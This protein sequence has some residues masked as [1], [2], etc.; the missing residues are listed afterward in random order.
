MPA[1][2]SNTNI[3]AALSSM[4]MLLSAGIPLPKV[5][6]NIA[7]VAGYPWR[8]AFNR[9]SERAAA[10][11]GFDACLMELKDAIPFA[12]RIM[13][14]IGWGSGRIDDI[15]PKIIYRRENLAETVRK[16]RSAMIQP[17]L[18]FL[19]A[20]FIIPFP[21]LILGSITPE[22][23]VMIA[24]SPI[25]LVGLVWLLIWI[26]LR[27]RMLQMSNQKITDPPASANFMDYLLLFI[28]FFRA[29]QV[30]RN[31]AE[32]CDLLG[33]LLYAGVRIDDA[34]RMTA[35]GLPNGVYR[36]KVLKMADT[37]RAGG[38]LR[39]ALDRSSLWPQGFVD[40]VEVADISGDL[41]QVLLKRAEGYREEYDRAVRTLGTVLARGFYVLVS[42][43]IAFHI[44]KGFTAYVGMINANLPP[45]STP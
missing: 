31:T 24:M 42:L 26:V 10:G 3:T 17:T 20:C 19:A 43:Y 37:T 18:T 34:L 11:E 16:F 13:L 23:Y 30:Y 36:A 33:N 12:E 7:D 28:P 1:S 4:R 45:G 40:I 38:E 8:A 39:D 27:G 14:S 35:T 15:L 21:P 6:R 32:F 41:E 2:P 22:R 9:A 44:I 5:F 29:M 25:L